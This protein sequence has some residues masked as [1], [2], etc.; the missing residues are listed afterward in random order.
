MQYQEREKNHPI[1]P[2]H[3]IYTVNEI[4]TPDKSKL[5]FYSRAETDERNTQ[6]S[7]TLTQRQS[8]QNF[9]CI[10]NKGYSNE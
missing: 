3:L 6:N 1:T 7:S 8:I 10:K 5:I 4:H 2:Y 9:V